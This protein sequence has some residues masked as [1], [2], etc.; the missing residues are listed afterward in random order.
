VSVA[1]SPVLIRAS[2][3]QGEDEPR[4]KEGGPAVAKKG[5][6][7][8]PIVGVRQLSTDGLSFLL[9]GPERGLGGL[10]AFPELL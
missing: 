2:E 10:K 3:G 5:L 9:C 4:E 1:P 6:T 8:H 7:D